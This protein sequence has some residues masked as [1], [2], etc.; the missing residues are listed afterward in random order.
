M[1]PTKV[2]ANKKIY[3]LCFAHFCP[4]PLFFEKNEIFKKKTAETQ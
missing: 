1:L 3:L 2:E 4:K